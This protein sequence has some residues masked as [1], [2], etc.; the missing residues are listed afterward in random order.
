MSTLEIVGIS[1]VLLILL[2]IF[3]KIFKTP[4]KLLLKLLFN[5]IGGF[6]A[7]MALNFFG[8]FIGISI[9]LNWVNAII[10]GIFGLPG[11]G[12]L[13]ILQLIL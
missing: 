5:T 9:G 12:L 2:V 6:I 3:I 1:I 7:L 13:L 11:I 10:V 4:L 8:S